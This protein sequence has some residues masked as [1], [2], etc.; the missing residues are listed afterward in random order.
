MR[1]PDPDARHPVMLPD[2]TPHEGTVHLSVAIDHP[3]I[4]AGAWSYAS[5]HAPPAD[6]AS[7]L[8]P[9]LYPFSEERLRLG[10]FVQVAHGARFVTGSANHPMDTLATYPF[11]HFSPD[12]GAFAQADARGIEIGSDVWI[13]TEALV[14][15]GARIGHGAIVGARAVVSGEVPPYAVVAGNPASVVRMR[16]DEAEV[17]RLLGVAWWDWDR[18]RIE[19]ALPAIL[20]GDVDALAALA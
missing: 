19:A 12:R 2:G 5:A 4:E 17:A 3:R 7:A 8:A 15:P 20:S 10:R 6:W 11:A 16:F 14:L 18:A 1:L 9:Y 13:G